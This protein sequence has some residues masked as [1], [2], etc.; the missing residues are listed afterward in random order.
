[1][2]RNPY[3]GPGTR[4][5]LPEPDIGIPGTPGAPAAPDGPPSG[6]ALKPPPGNTVETADVA[7]AAA[8]QLCGADNA[9]IMVARPMPADTAPLPGLD[10]VARFGASAFGV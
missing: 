4:V 1:M 9:P 8:A 3:L 10:A 2:T 5:L 7:G 6:A